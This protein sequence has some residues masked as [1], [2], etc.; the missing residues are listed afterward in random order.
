[1]SGTGLTD[2]FPPGGVDAHDASLLSCPLPYLIVLFI[3][4]SI[5]QTTSLRCDGYWKVCYPSPPC[6]PL[7]DYSHE[8]YI[9]ANTLDMYQNFAP[10]LK[11]RYLSSNVN[12][13]VA[14]KNNNTIDVPVGSTPPSINVPVPDRILQIDL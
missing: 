2:G 14:D 3:G 1:M 5:R 7:T 8:L 9:Y 13:T 4:Q 6:L 11:G 10:A 12:I